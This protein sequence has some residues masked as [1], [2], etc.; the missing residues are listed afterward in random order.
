LLLRISLL[1]IY[2]EARIFIVNF[3]LFHFNV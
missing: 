3:C 1:V 2:V